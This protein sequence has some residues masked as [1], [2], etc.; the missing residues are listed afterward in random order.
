MATS[1]KGPRFNP[2]NAALPITTGL[3]RADMATDGPRTRRM[4]PSSAATPAAVGHMRNMDPGKASSQT[5]RNRRP[6]DRRRGDQS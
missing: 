6:P 5:L 3:P 1:S 4:A 2:N